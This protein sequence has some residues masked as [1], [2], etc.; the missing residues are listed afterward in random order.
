MDRIQKNG[1]TAGIVSAV[2]LAI[3]VVLFMSLG[4]DVMTPGDP[5]KS[6]SAAR[7]KWSMFRLASLA[8]MAAAGVA[9]VFVVGIATRLRE[10]AP[11]RARV[12]L[13][14]VLIG[15]GAYALGSAM[16]LVGGPQILAFAG[17]D[18]AGGTA[19]WAAISAVGAGFDGLGNT[20]SGAGT[21]V[22]A[23]A[24][25]DTKLLPAGV[26]WI[27]VISGVLNVANLF[28]MGS[29]AVMLGG[30]IATIIWLAWGGAALRGS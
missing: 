14:L 19:A 5:A 10:A 27:G 20:F 3:L 1:G 4:E 8:G 23:W 13:Y 7:D 30:F 21:L 25:L 2:L 11:T 17:K 22:A 24:I 29:P 9:V 12:L 26:A 28:A 18:Q 16:W 6:L 15:L